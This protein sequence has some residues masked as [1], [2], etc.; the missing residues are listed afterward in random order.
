ME[1]IKFNWDHSVDYLTNSFNRRIHTELKTNSFIYSYN[2]RLINY[3]IEDIKTNSPYLK[4][5][6]KDT[7]D[8]VKSILLFKNIIS[9]QAYTDSRGF[10]FN[11]MIDETKNKKIKVAGFSIK[12]FDHEI[13]CPEHDIIKYP[14]KAPDTKFIEEKYNDLVFSSS[15]EVLS[16]ALLMLSFS[17]L[18]VIQLVKKTLDAEMLHQEQLAYIKGNLKEF[19]K[20]EELFIKLLRY[21]YSQIVMRGDTITEGK[22]ADEMGLPRNTYRDY[23]NEKFKLEI[24]KETGEIAKRQT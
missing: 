21:S 24:N 10:D 15:Y 19:N 22:I 3:F 7:V 16:A 12:I 6:N 17:K 18:S 2:S 8:A 13:E 14:Y 11:E 20:T 23:M 4:E 1:E 5:L 9:V